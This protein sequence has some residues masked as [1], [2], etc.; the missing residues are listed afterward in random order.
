MQKLK[1]DEHP[2][3]KMSKSHLKSHFDSTTCIIKRLKP[4]YLPNILAIFLSG[5]Q[6]PQVH[7]IPPSP[8]P[9]ASSPTPRR[10][11]RAP[12]EYS[13]MANHARKAGKTPDSPGTSRGLAL[14]LKRQKKC[15][16]AEDEVQ[17]FEDTDEPT[18]PEPS[19]PPVDLVPQGRVEPAAAIKALRGS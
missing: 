6:G 1:I 15:T 9:L 10:P 7:I 13:E 5:N 19:G 14:F 12:P 3:F 8:P 18:R 2:L 4:M 17:K 11:H 16:D